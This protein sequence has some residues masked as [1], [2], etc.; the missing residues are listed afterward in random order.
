MNLSPHFSLQEFVTSDYAIRHGLKM[1]PDAVHITNMKRLCD[2]VLEP[3]RL[4][5]GKPLKITSGFRSP[6]LNQAIGGSSAS[7]HC[8]G[9][10]ADITM[11]GVPNMTLAKHIYA[12]LPFDQLILEYPERG[13]WVHVSLRER[14]NRRD[15]LTFTHGRYVKGLI[16][17]KTGT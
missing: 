7:Q 5:F 6:E 13:G 16:E 4:F 15:V 11:A 2:T 3:L 17:N 10:A 12:A 9:E 8:Q 1:E 14:L